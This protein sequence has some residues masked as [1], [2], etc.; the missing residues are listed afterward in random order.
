MN[1][2]GGL[3]LSRAL[4]EARPPSDGA[5]RDLLRRRFSYHPDDR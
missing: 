1:C 3:T 5:R 4:R 2:T